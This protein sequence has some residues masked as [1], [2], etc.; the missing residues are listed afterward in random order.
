MDYHDFL[1]ACH[2]LNDSNTLTIDSQCRWKAI[3]SKY[4][5]FNSLSVHIY[6]ILPETHIPIALLF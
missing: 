1:T 3:N 5:C 4:N 2:F 6:C